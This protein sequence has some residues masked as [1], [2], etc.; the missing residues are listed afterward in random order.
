VRVTWETAPSAS[1]QRTKICVPL[2][3]ASAR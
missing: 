2:S 3:S 1:I